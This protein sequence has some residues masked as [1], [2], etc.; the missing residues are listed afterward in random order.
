MIFLLKFVFQ[1]YLVVIRV[2]QLSKG[3]KEVKIM[4]GHA[5]CLEITKWT[6]I[7]LIVGTEIT[8]AVSNFIYMK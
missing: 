8:F 6:F 4:P 3:V 2:S 7:F 1:Y 5:K